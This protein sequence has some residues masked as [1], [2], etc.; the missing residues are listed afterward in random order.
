[1]PRP[2]TSD[3]ADLFE[4]ADRYPRAPG[5]KA[6]DTSA[7]AAAEVK[8]KAPLLRNLCLDLLIASTGLTADEVAGR[9]GF[10]VLSIRP[11]LTEL[12]ALGLIIDSGERRRNASGK[13][14]IVW[15]IA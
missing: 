7:E 12:S 13:R 1:M 6:R 15:K 4:A 11:R 14:A 9:A 10:S 5:F 3:P 2:S 8:P